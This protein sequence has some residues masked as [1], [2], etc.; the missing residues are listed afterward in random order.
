MTRYFGYKAW[1]SKLEMRRYWKY[2]WLKKMPCVTFKR[3]L[4]ELADAFAWASGGVRYKTT[5]RWFDNYA[6][7]EKYHLRIVNE[8]IAII[9]WG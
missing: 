1:N 9:P 3:E 2:L 6:E 5:S 7:A 8:G 4:G